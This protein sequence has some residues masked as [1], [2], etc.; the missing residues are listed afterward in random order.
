MHAFSFFFVRS[1]LCDAF[2][3]FCVSV[4]P[5]FLFFLCAHLSVMRV[6]V[7]SFFCVRVPNSFLFFLCVLTFL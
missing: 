1:T 5:F 4:P 6:P 3:F 2:S 7:F